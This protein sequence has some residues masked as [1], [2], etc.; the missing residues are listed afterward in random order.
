MSDN[1]KVYEV[2]LENYYVLNVV[3]SFVTYVG[4]YVTRNLNAS[5]AALT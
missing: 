4:C 3:T 2:L 1:R 5:A